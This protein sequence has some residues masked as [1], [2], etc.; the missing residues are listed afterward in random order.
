MLSIDPF[1]FLYPQSGRK[2]SFPAHMIKPGQRKIVSNYTKR[3]V[4]R[5]DG[6]H[7]IIE[8]QLGPIRFTMDARNQATHRPFNHKLII[9]ETGLSLDDNDLRIQKIYRWLFA[10][11]Q[12]NS[13]IFDDALLALEEGRSPILLTE[14][15]EHLEYFADRLRKF[16]RNLIVLQGGR[17]AT[18][19]DNLTRDTRTCMQVDLA[20]DS[21]YD[22]PFALKNEPLKPSQAFEVK[23]LFMAG[24]GQRRTQL[25][26][27]I[28]SNFG[29]N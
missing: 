23:H 17:S 14:R 10:D 7:P 26:G 3:T 13:L 27:L 9:C 18:H 29:A 8:M 16:T 19:D 28:G 20:L 15:K 6:H 2:Y 12:R 25:S 22:Q 5:R 21:K 4:K 1:V 24:M 11:K